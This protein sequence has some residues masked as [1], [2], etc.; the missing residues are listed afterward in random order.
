MQDDTEN[1][2]IRINN[3]L[4]HLVGRRLMNHSAETEIKAMIEDEISRAFQMGA[5][6]LDDAG[7][8]P[9]E[10]MSVLIDIDLRTGRANVSIGRK[11]TLRPTANAR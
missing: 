2:R 10:E 7:E 8:I 5:Q 4:D 6:F 1:L 9:E 3:R 11:H